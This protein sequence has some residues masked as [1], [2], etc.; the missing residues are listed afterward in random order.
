MPQITIKEAIQEIGSLTDDKPIIDILRPWM[1]ITGLTFKDAL[2]LSH[3]EA[4]EGLKAVHNKLGEVLDVLDED[5]LQEAAC[6]CLKDITVYGEMMS[7][8]DVTVRHGQN[9]NWD[10]TAWIYISDP[11]LRQRDSSK[12]YAEALKIVREIVDS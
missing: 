9:L 8:G 3:G 12:S 1:A 2:H 5:Q 7:H 4:I 11:K 10:G 6:R